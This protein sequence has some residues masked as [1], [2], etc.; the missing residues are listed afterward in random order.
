MGFP[1]FVE[2]P[3]SFAMNLQNISREKAEKEGDWN[4]K[5]CEIF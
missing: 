1:I 5:N 4:I 3:T 2:G